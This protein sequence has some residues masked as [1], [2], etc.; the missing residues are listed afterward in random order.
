[1]RKRESGKEMERKERETEWR[2]DLVLNGV[3]N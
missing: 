1:M 3:N 2:T